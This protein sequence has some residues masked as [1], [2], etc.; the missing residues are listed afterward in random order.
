APQ[1][2]PVKGQVSKCNMCVD[3]LEVGLKPACVAA[4]V[5]NAL[6]FGII[7]T[8]PEGREQARVEIPG[9]PSPEIT[10]PNIRFQQIKQLPDEMKRTD[11][12]P[13]KYHRDDQG[14][15]RPAIDPKQGHARHWN[16]KRLSSRENPLVL[17]TLSAQAA[18]GAFALAFLGA[19]AGLPGFGAFAASALYV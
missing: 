19:W 14:R 18:V 17:F 8:V 10:K 11:S 5:G 16:L 13:V 2:D 9:F 7:E 1:L 15:Y 12:M 6:D 3:R 4:C